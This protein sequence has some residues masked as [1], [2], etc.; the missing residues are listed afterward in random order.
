MHIDIKQ[1]L[2]NII[3][4]TKNLKDT[5]IRKHP[6]SKYSIELIISELLYF[7]KSGVSWRMLRSPI[8]FKT[9]H[10]FYLLF[11]KRNIFI[12]LYN[13]IKSKYIKNYNSNNTYFIDST[14]I[15]NKN[16]T[17][18]IGRNKMINKKH[19]QLLTTIINE[20]PIA[21]H[22]ILDIQIIQLI[23]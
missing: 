14:V 1:E 16:G 22:T 12:K 19:L 13:K 6:N 11:V 23:V 7:L 4:K 9:L 5:F 8:N 15:N 10:Y 21:N 2:K 20:D 3:L 17:N 18:K